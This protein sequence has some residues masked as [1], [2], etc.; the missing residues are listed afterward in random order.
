M[1]N[2]LWGKKIPGIFFGFLFSC[3][4]F[5]QTPAGDTLTLSIP[6]AE[7]IFLQ[8]NLALLAN[9]YNIDVNKALVDQAKVWDN[10]VL[11]TDQ[12]IY[13]GKFF[14]H[15]TTNGVAYGQVYIQLQQLVRT[16]GKRRKGI[17]LAE[18]NV[19]SAAVQFTDLMRNLRYVLTTDL[20]TLSQLQGI[21]AVWQNEMVTM[22]KLAYGMDEMLKVGDISQKDNIR[23]KAL[24]FSLQGDYA[25]NLRQQQDLQKEIRTI[26]QL[27]DSTWVIADAGRKLDAAALAK[28][29]VGTLMDTALAIRPDLALAQN[30]LLLQQHNLIYQKALAKP[31][32]TV[33]V[34]YDK[35][36]S[37]VPN[38]YGLA[39]SVPLPLFNKNKGNIAAAQ[40]SVQQAG[41]YVQQAQQQVTHDVWN[42]WQK[43]NIA[44]SLINDENLAWQTNYDTLLKNMTESYTKRQVSLLE[45]IDFFEAWKETRSRQLA[46]VANERNAAAELNYATNQPV[47]KL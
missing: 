37:Y 26:L 4:V 23:I 35:L 6:K 12:N 40:A 45:F 14:R 39:L 19:K 29:S 34:E 31:D 17:Q 21:A 20:N 33:G 2:N 27:P 15:T 5:A 38:Y 44:S 7:T 32:V 25:D 47:I 11:L 8:K 43:L 16:A 13:D 22:R 24:L 3:G 46:Q 36:N 10:P 18:D 30:Q 1:L 9:Q 41:V 42:A 28:V